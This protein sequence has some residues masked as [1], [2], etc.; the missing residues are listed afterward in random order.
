M[1]GNSMPHGSVYDIVIIGTGFGALSAA[2]IL[3]AYGYTPLLLESHYAAGGVAHGFS[4]KNPAGDFH[5]DTG[6]SFFCDLDSRFSLNPLKQALDAVEEHVKCISYPSFCIDDLRVGSVSISSDEEDV[7]KQVHRLVG[8]DAANQLR[9]FYKVMRRIHT[10]MN[11]PAVALRGD[12]RVMPV[13]SRRWAIEMLSLLPYV[14]D[15]TRPVGDIMKRLGVIHPFVKRILDTEAFLLSGLKTDSTITAEIAFMIGERAKP[16]ALQY[17]V[18]GVR[19]IVR[20]FVRGIERKGG[21]VRL[22][23]HVQRILVEDGVAVGVDLRSGERIFAKHIFSN[24][25]LWDTVE[26]LLPKDSLPA[27]YRKS[28]LQTPMVESFVHAHMAIPSDGL[29]DI[30]GHHAVIMDSEKDIALPGNTVMISIPTMWSPDLAPEGWHIIHCYTLDNYDKWPALRSDRDLYEATKNE[31]ARP[32]Y[33]AVRHVIPD[34][35]ERLKHEHAFVKIG[36]PLTHAR[37]NRRYKGTYGAAIV[38]GKSEFEWPDDIPI[39]NLMR[40]GDSV[41]PG[42]GVPSSAAAGIIAANQL[43]GIREHNELVDKI[44]PR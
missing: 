17:P 37:F 33:E 40:C 7:L 34:L 18:G 21:S 44:F 28:A 1:Q 26:N 42:I 43:V 25:S 15:V 12:W 11:V 4:I 16:N 36:S 31:A 8:G 29:Q 41:F 3:T 20:A 23:S 2:S 24:A 30:V 6:P 22:K 38:A 5:F 9:S 10:G 39:K 14:K 35:D 19:S 13:V 32:L 27:A